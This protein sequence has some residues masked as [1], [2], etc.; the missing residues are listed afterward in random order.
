LAVKARR[1][2]KRP[3]RRKPAAAGDAFRRLPLGSLRV[4]VAVAE[5]LHFT[6]A[7]AALGVSASATS[8]QVH[9]LERY[10]GVTLF[11][12][13]GRFVELT[14]HGVQLLPRVRDGLSALQGAIDDAR[15]VEGH[16]PLRVSTL[17]SFLTQWLMPRL[18]RFEAGHPGI[19]LRIE[20]STEL[21]DF[22]RSD[23]H[24]AIRLGAGP[25][26]GVYSEKFMDEWL[27]PVCRPALLANLGPVNGHSDLKRY[28]LLHSSSEPWSL[29]LLDAP[30]NDVT[31]R[32]S[33]DD[34]TA[35]VRAAEAG[36]GLALARWSLVADEIR[37]GRLALAGRQAAQYPLA[38]HFVCPAKHKEMPK[39][40]AF[41]GWLR[42]EAAKHRPP[43]RS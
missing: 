11:H 20:T 26:A 32:I 1:T 38:Y 13:Q 8:M 18:P 37:S 5:H 10:L 23:I 16:G 7:A 29:W 33:I 6:R 2:G 12:R 43:G 4:F 40:A 17:G 39:V 35:I 36:G 27:V 19:E 41:H 31:S 14:A 15:E 28:R 30:H 42:S 25:W 3:P 24:A 22:K 9:A 34:S 21:I